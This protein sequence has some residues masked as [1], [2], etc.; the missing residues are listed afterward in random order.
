MKKHFG[1]FL[2]LM[3]VAMSLVVCAFGFAACGE[4]KAADP[5]ETYIMTTTGES[6]F[7][8]T[9]GQKTSDIVVYLLELYEDGTY[10]L[11]ETRDMQMYNMHLPQT[12]V[13]YG[14]FEKS[15]AVDGETPIKLTPDRVIY[16]AC[17]TLQGGFNIV[18]D[19]NTTT[20]PVR[21]PGQQTADTSLEQ[22]NA[23]YKVTMN[24]VLM[25]TAEGFST[26]NMMKL[27]D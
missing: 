19:T 23:K 11:T 18:V 26:P 2:A 14:A 21:M 13:T 8:G 17:S 25:E 7:S 27:P 15:A 6:E 10:R 3:A 24:F 1:K 20:F 16:N 4:T 22:F 5:T 9:G 12:V